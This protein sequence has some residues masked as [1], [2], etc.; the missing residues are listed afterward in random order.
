MKYI[1]TQTNHGNIVTF[2]LKGVVGKT[3]GAFRYRM[4]INWKR[5]KS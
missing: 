3:E 2:G 4:K 1:Y 5:N